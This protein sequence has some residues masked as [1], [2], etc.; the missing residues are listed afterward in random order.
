MSRTE[1]KV[2]IFKIVVLWVMKLIC[3][4]CFVN[5]VKSLVQRRQLYL[6]FK[7]HCSGLRRRR[8][9]QQ[10]AGGGGGGKGGLTQKQTECNVVNPRTGQPYT[11]DELAAG[12]NRHES[13]LERVGS[14]A[15]EALS[16]ALCAAELAAPDALPRSTDKVVHNPTAKE[17]LFGK[18][19]DR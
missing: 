8:L 7:S 5:L 18:G 13:L 3:S 4:G 16:T 12:H 15:E 19:A 1:R 10:Q 17:A 14:G 2:Q 11:M 6:V 9:Q